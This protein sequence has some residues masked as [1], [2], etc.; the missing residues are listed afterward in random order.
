MLQHAE[1]FLGKINEIDHTLRFDL[2]SLR[3][4]IKRQLEPVTSRIVLIILIP[5]SPIF[6]RCDSDL[7]EIRLEPAADECFLSSRKFAINLV[8][9]LRNLQLIL[10]F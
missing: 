6:I 1:S 2:T 5:S 8:L 4:P 10:F 9:V 7:I 3:L